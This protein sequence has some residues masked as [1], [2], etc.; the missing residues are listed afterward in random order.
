MPCSHTLL[1]ISSLIV[2]ALRMYFLDLLTALKG[3]LGW[4]VITITAAEITEIS[5][6][7][8]RVDLEDL[9]D[10]PDPQARSA[11]AQQLL[12]LAQATPQVCY[13]TCPAIRTTLC[14]AL[15]ARFLVFVCCFLVAY[16]A[17]WAVTH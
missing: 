14:S 7:R 9:L 12:R 5:T 3:K 8:L 2:F 16:W 11:A 6:H 10:R 13:P 4:K 15:L 1:C 17:T